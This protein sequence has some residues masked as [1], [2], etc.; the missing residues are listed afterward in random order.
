MAGF[1]N[2][3]AFG[4]QQQPAPAPA[5]ATT[6][7]APL[8]AQ[9][10]ASFSFDEQK[11]VS[12]DS[13]DKQQLAVFQWLMTLEKDIGTA[14]SD[15]I[16][17][18]QKVLEKQLFRF[19]HPS[20][21]PTR[22]TVAIRTHIATVFIA[23]YT[24]GEN[25]TVFDTMIAC[26][27]FLNSKE[28]IVKDDAS[29]SSSRLLGVT[30]L[31]LL[32]ERFGARFLSLFPETVSL[33]SR[34]LK[35]NIDLG[36][37][38]EIL[39]ALAAAIRGGGRGMTD[40]LFKDVN[41]QLKSLLSDKHHGIRE[42]AAKCLT[43]MVKYTTYMQPATVAD[44]ET[45]MASAVK[46][47][48]GTIY[49][50]RVAVAQLI[51]EY[52]AT[53]QDPTSQAGGSGSGSKST[54]RRLKLGLRSRGG[55]AGGSISPTLGDG[56]GGAGAAQ[57]LTSSSL[58]TCGDMLS[59]LSSAVARHHARDVRVGLFEAYATL[60][61]CLGA[62][63]VETNYADIV[64]H[65]AARLLNNPKLVAIPR[66]ELMAVREMATWVLRRVIGQG[67]LSEEGQ[68]TAAR[69]LT[70]QH[71]SKWP[72]KPSEPQPSKIALTVFL[73]EL[74]GLVEHL[75]GGANAL[76]DFIVEPVLTLLGHLSHSVQIAAAWCLRRICLYI[77]SQIPTVTTQL[78]AS[79]QKDVQGLVNSV[80]S[81][82]V[83]KRC[84]GQ[85]YGLAAVLS[86][87]HHR[88]MYVSFETTAKVFAFALQLMKSANPGSYR[89]IR[90]SIGIN[91]VAW[92]TLTGLM[93]IG[94]MF[95]KIHLSQIFL[96]WKAAF[97]KLTGSV[98]GPKVEKE[99]FHYLHARELALSSLY[100]FLIFNESLL[101]TDVLKRVSTFLGNALILSTLLPKPATF[102]PTSTT[103]PPSSSS[104]AH[105]PITCRYVDMDYMFR[106]RL[107]D[108]IGRLQPVT[109]FE[110]SF[111]QLIRPLIDIFAIEPAEAQ[112]VFY[113]TAPYASISTF[114]TLAAA[115]SAG[116][117]NWSAAEH[118][119]SSLLRRVGD[120]V[121]FVRKHASDPTRHGAHGVEDSGAWAL[122]FFQE[123]EEKLYH[124]IVPCYE[125]DPLSVFGTPHSPDNRA[126]DDR[127]QAQATLPVPP[128]YG[129]VDTAIKTFAVIFPFLAVN[130]QDDLLDLL[131]RTIKQKYDK[132]GRK[133]AVHLNVLI[134]LLGMARE[135]A[136]VRLSKKQEIIQKLTPLSGKGSSA[137]W[138]LLQAGFGSTD[139]AVRHLSAS[140]LGLT[141]SAVGQ[142]AVQAFLPALVDQVVNNRDPSYRAGFALGIGRVIEQSSSLVSVAQLRTAV[143]ILH[144]LATDAHSTVHT[145]AL[146][147]L[148]LL[149]E[150]AGLNFSPFI[151]STL[152]VAAKAVLSDDH[153]PWAAQI[154]T[155]SGL[156]EVG[157]NVGRVVCSCI[158]VLGPELQI[159]GKIRE[160]TTDLANHLLA[161]ESVGSLGAADAVTEAL[162]CYQ[163]FI[164][165]SPK[166]F[167]TADIVPLLQRYLAPDVQLQRKKAALTCLWQLVQREPGTVLQASDGSLEEQMFAVVDSVDDDAVYR[168][169]RKILSAL[170]EFNGALKPTRWINLCRFM[171]TKQEA[172]DM[173]QQQQQGH[174]SGG[175][176]DDDSDAIRVGEQASAPK[177]GAT[178]KQ[179]VPQWK[180]QLISLWCLRQVIANIRQVSNAEAHLN[181]A[182]A[183]E[184]RRAT[185]GKKPSDDFLV[186][187]VADLIKLAFTATTAASHDIRS[188]G[189]GVLEDILDNFATSPD[190]DYAGHALL[191]Q[192][193][194]QFTSALAPAFASDSSP[195]IL[196]KACQVS[197]H[198]IG[199]GITE[200]LYTL[201][202]I[203]GHLRNQLQLL[204]DNLR[205]VSRKHRYIDEVVDPHV[206]VLLPMWVKAVQE[207]ALIKI[208][209]DYSAANTKLDQSDSL[210]TATTRDVLLPYY[211]KAWPS[212]L[213]ALSTFAASGHEPIM[214]IAR[215]SGQASMADALATS[216]RPSSINDVRA[217]ALSCNRLFVLLFGLCLEP[218]MSTRGNSDQVLQVCL[219]SLK[220]I[221]V[222]GF[223]GSPYL[224]PLLLRD[225]SFAFERIMQTEGPEM[226]LTVI[227]T[228][229]QLVRN[230]LGGSSDSTD[231]RVV[232]VE[233]L[234][235]ILNLLFKVW[236]I[237]LPQLSTDPAA[238]LFYQ[239]REDT[240]KDVMFSLALDC[241]QAL[242][243]CS[244]AP[245]EKSNM[246]A[247]TFAI[248]EEPLSQ[249]AS[250]KCLVILKETMSADSAPSSQPPTPALEALAYG[251]LDSIQDAIEDEF[252]PDSWKVIEN[253]LLAITILVTT[254]PARFTE[255][256]I[257]ALLLN[258]LPNILSKQRGQ[259]FSS[260]FQCLKSLSALA[261]LE[262]EV[263]RR[264]GKVFA[265]YTA[266]HTLIHLQ[267]YCASRNASELD[268]THIENCLTT[269]TAAF[270]VCDETQKQQL[271]PLLLSGY[272]ALLDSQCGLA[273]KMYN[274]IL[275]Q[276]LAIAGN[277][278]L[279]PQFKAIVGQLPPAAK[280]TLETSLRTG[281]RAA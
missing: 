94:P 116:S 80:Y 190:P 126:A 62:T 102:T 63:Y 97:P 174:T 244:M 162:R 240:Q 152:A 83:L 19:L 153:G 34:L 192:Y 169:V 4:G 24:F 199:S 193:Q 194:A 28:K 267:A 133:T 104:S 157:R 247:F 9:P 115:M 173:Q 56:E 189:L 207:Y 150:A 58:C 222:P 122:G 246:Q 221:L 31:G 3:A 249:Q 261:L 53:T 208:E 263:V 167:P 129:L 232:S 166:E 223:M 120:D 155:L 170:V 195:D 258:I 5:L 20:T 236:V 154:S 160:L 88:P 186:F 114:G 17:A 125:Y 234:R 93:T 219:M 277:A 27:S 142:Q 241:L 89:D 68:I 60:F 66:M 179:L 274:A 257:P 188:E 265:A 111:P 134:M 84:V 131:S 10:P 204:A 70:E 279:L 217:N 242:A 172:Q 85:S 253:G 266:T 233:Y 201:S 37:K 168:D 237:N 268:D 218:F 239:Q 26:Q 158:G 231:N 59:F 16:K 40:A 178:N 202:R 50:D 45:F 276:V 264:L 44:V 228:L 36:A 130:I 230:C 127:Q 8:P 200:D 140:T 275:T 196:A 55:T 149:I 225:M 117:A 213:D 165:L 6:T 271:L 124:P 25:R 147:S 35:T 71:L 81:A 101:S 139:P 224:D 98:P 159:A 33:F 281:I 177:P 256:P 176:T 78:L 90:T 227:E 216:S 75:A 148:W 86:V 185:G 255:S 23:L 175:E 212:I 91:H 191:E 47:L 209:P 161:D 197:S 137:I 272:V 171:L 87:A 270:G 156:P 278:V 226:Q 251:L 30:V 92:M 121:D 259:S 215:S 141:T 38:V 29:L 138:E 12:L 198:Y 181:L 74:G 118:G 22:P 67:L 11:I 136:D 123:L 119:V 135:Y 260:I 77:P 106:K 180:S 273:A 235:P 99:W 220:G 15:L 82:D 109:V 203:I 105:Y 163:N 52:L 13:L 238:F 110:S 95:T 205:V 144:S 280:Q 184:K 7:P 69:V 103:P 96:L 2:F 206:D 21:A 128:T 57:A 1:A 229:R 182:V 32:S 210:Y 254:S 49:C 146:Q 145:Y 245:A 143:G 51:A 41:K 46:A 48:E 214:A 100:T 243:K 187:K 151:N 64:Q 262:V 65:L 79:L 108:C 132:Q 72:A 252:S 250:S 248:V 211:V 107:Y 54:T 113:V 42:Q 39:A 18:H 76:Q 61:E 73:Y 164:L 112:R 14:P 269:I 43:S 183:R